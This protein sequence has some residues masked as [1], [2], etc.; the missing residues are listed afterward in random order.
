VRY[1][2]DAGFGTFA[3]HVDRVRA[4]GRVI[5]RDSEFH[6]FR[7]GIRVGRDSEERHKN[8]EAAEN[9]IADVHR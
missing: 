6:R 8:G 2:L 1:D 7:C 9:G 4:D 5:A 3:D